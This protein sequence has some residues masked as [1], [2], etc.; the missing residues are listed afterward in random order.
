MLRRMAE[1]STQIS[2][3]KTPDEVWKLVG[4]FGGLAGWMPGIEACELEGDVRHIK[5]MGLDIDEKLN[6]L[7]DTN[8]VVR[9]S[10]VKSPM[11]LEFHEATI[12]VA[13]EGDGTSVTW[14]VEVRPDEMLGAFLPIYEGSLGAVKTHFD[15]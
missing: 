2:V 1:G 3:A 7:D 10:I 4:D 5:T 13:P 11:P 15:G 8:R 9:Y 6:E 14:K 12:T